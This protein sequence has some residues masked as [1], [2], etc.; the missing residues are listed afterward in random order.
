MIV[1]GKVDGTALLSSE[2][3]KGESIMKA[4][5]VT[6]QHGDQDRLACCSRREFLGKTAAIALAGAAT[7]GAVASETQGTGPSRWTMRLS[8][9][10]IHFMALRI[11][12]ACARIA[13]LGFEAIDIWS[14]HAGCP[15]LDDVQKRLGAGGLRRILEKNNLKLFSFSVYRGGY[16]RYAKLLGQLGGGVA[17]RGSTR[18]DKGQPLTVQMRKFLESLKP[19]IEL[20]EKYDSYLAIENHGHALLNTL[21]SLKAFVD[22]NQSP[23]VGIALAPFH[24]QR[25]KASVVEAIRISGRQLFFFY[26][27]QRASTKS[28]NQLP[29]HG[30]TDFTPWIA[31]LAEVGYRGYVN[32]F[33]HGEVEPDKM[34]AALAK[35]K[36]YLESC[37]RRA[38]SGS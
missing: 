3:D 27:W 38:V 28:F 11:E 17:V 6:V 30:P 9:S 26:A 29:G 23:R 4:R 22:L 14:A 5:F 18:F 25:L 1:V 10:S 35:A 16:P 21:D 24:V 32:P 19:E 31:A 37:Y 13:R 12:E 34:S 8:T 36:T 7:P 33:M 2:R 20:A 15:H